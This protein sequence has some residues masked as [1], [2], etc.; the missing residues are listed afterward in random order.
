[1][2]LIQVTLAATATPI[3]TNTALYASS[4]TIQNNTAHATRVGDNTVTASK[5]I[6]LV[7]SGAIGSTLQIQPSTPRGIHLSEVY[8]FGTAADVIDVL[9]EGPA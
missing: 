5:G 4:L 1:M 7:V 2:R 8:I 6:S 3:T 9:Y